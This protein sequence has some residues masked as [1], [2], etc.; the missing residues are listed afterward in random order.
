MSDTPVLIAGA[1]P[2][3][4]VLAKELAHHGVRSTIVERN[5]DTTRWPK[6]DITNCRSMELLRR[7]GL[8]KGLREVGV[9]SRHSF[10]VL[11]STGLT[12]RCF[13]R[14]SLPSVD[15]WRERIGARND[16]SMPQVPYQRCSQAIFEAWL[17]RLC[18][19]DPLITVRSGWRF[20]DLSQD[21]DGVTARIVD[22]DGGEHRLRAQ[23]LVGCDGAS[24]AV[25]K[26][27]G[28]ALHGR[29]LPR[30][31]RLVH[32][33]S[34]DL[35]A[36]HAH[37]QFWHIFFT[38][39]ATLIAQDEVDTWTLI[40]YFPLEV[41]P[42]QFRSE[43]LVAESLGRRVQIDEVIVT[44]VWRGNLLLAERYR[45]GRVFLAGDS[46]HQNIPTGGY[47]MNTGVGDAIDIGW[48][49]AA[50]LNGWGGPAL[51]D[52]YERERR[53]V[54]E[55]NVARS[56]RHANVHVQWRARVDPGLIDADGAAGEAHRQ[57]LAEFIRTEDGEN[58]D[59]GIE[60]GYRY[61]D[62]PI[63]V[64]ESTDAPPWTPRHY[65]PTT[66]PGGRAPSV[67]LADGSS[68]FDRFGRAFTLVDFAGGDGG[69]SLIQAATARGLPIEHLV[70]NDPHARAI[71]ERD[72]VLIRPD[73]HVAW[74]GNTPPADSARMIDLV[75]GYSEHHAV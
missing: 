43:D 46:V 27:L 5:L 8:E 59:H 4:L 1:G 57:E 38:T 62:S 29:A 36:L 31:A 25:R 54:A 53:P 21:A 2:V 63:V 34:R 32:F 75:R 28:I 71:Y 20:D 35:T 17:K 55:R 47:G 16:G 11:F 18:E 74:R 26:S 70:V 72:L 3:G 52:S 40:R 68:L 58:Q 44:S 37:G 65:V 6:M 51:L 30:H 56:E 22:L 61:D 33:K 39:P 49:L 19:Q 66:W 7:L 13:T 64:L 9:P 50:V 45:E 41:D 15:D 12:G 42:A 23:Y 24:S 48:K 14:W 73:Q 67:L 69:R 10:D 60:L